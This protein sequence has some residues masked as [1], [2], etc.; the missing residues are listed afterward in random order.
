[1]I[2]RATSVAVTL[3]LTRTLGMAGYGRIEF[4]FNVVFWLVLL[5]RDSIEVIAARELARHPRLI[6]PLVNHVLAA[7]GLFALLLFGGLLLVGVLGLKQPAD[8]AILWLYGLMLLTTAMGLDF[9]YRGTERMALVAVSLCIRTLIYAAGVW[10]LVTSER[11]IWVPALLTLGEVSGIALVWGC[12]AREYGLP[13]PVLGL[14]FLRVFLRRGRSV[15]LIQFAQTIISSVD[16][17]VVVGLMSQWADV[18]EYGAPHRVITAVLTFG[19]IFQQVAFPMLA[20]SWRQTACAG[21]ETLNGLIQV[22]VLVLLPVAVGGT[23]LAG[24]LVQLLP[25]EFSG[26][27]VLLAIGI[28]RAPLLTLA[29]LYQT[30]LIAVNCESVGVRL[31]LLGAFGSGPLVALFCS[32]FGL[33]GVSVAVVLIALALVIA[34][35]GCL[36]R[37]GRQPAWH[38]HLARPLAASLAMIPACL[39][40]VRWHVLAAVAGGA[41]VYMIVLAAVGGFRQ[42]GVRAILARSHTHA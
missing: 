25:K 41:L 3:S 15:C 23:V 26:A 2:C 33:P 4:A 13:R 22:L 11:M 32:V 19:L 18:G 37:E 6:R 20:R 35:Y 12:Y 16:V 21:R 27:S 17:M 5:V 40:L 14:R 8:R 7:K 30:T 42:P 38:H 36:A 34:G 31:L 29:F 10:L 9:V 28:W 24:P 39:L 1:V